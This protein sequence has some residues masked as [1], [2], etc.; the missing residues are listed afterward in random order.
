[1]AH[2]SAKALAKQVRHLDEKGPAV[3]AEAGN[4]LAGEGMCFDVVEIVVVADVQRSAGTWGPAGEQLR[5]Q[6]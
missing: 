6:L 2:L 5:A 1:M 3:T 4:D